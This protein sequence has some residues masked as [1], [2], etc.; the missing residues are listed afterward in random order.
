MVVC[1]Q[2]HFLNGLLSTSA[3]TWS[4]QVWSLC[5]RQR[6]TECMRRVEIWLQSCLTWALDGHEWW[7]SC[8]T[9]IHSCQELDDSSAIQPVT[10]INTANPPPPSLA[11]IQTNMLLTQT[12]LLRFAE[13]ASE[14][15][16]FISHR[17]AP[18][19]FGQW[20]INSLVI[21][22][23][24]MYLNI[25]PL[26][27]FY[28]GTLHDQQPSNLW[29]FRMLPPSKQGCTLNS[30]FSNRKWQSKYRND[31]VME[32]VRAYAHTLQCNKPTPT[33][34][35]WLHNTSIKYIYL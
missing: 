1:I 6:C 17:T 24:S 25:M 26:G 30:T 27:S 29:R 35:K 33:D 3:R 18:G 32:I 28:L 9:Q 7:V 11:S 34:V 14:I 22:N 19:Y 23:L 20:V 31:A 2:T 4:L 16:T 5:K 15:R 12:N 21:Q 13:K 8:F 10:I